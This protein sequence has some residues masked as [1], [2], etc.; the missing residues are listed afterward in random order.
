[1]SI[2]KIKNYNQKM[3]AVL[4]TLGIVLLF[5]C[6]I[7]IITDMW[8]RGYHEEVPQGLIADDKTAE[9]N[10]ENLRKQIISY[11][12]PW[13]IDTL[14]STYI[15]P[16]SIRTLKKP[17]EVVALDNG[18]LGLMDTYPGSMRFN[19]GGYY[20]SKRF[21][22]KYANLIVY[23]AVKEKAESLFSERI[24]I[25]NTQAYYF[26][27]DILLIFYLASSDTDK[28]GIIDLNDLRSLY[29]YSLN[30]GVM[31]KVS[32]GD[33]QVTDYMFEERSKN[34]LIEFQLGQYKE[35]QFE[36]DQSPKKIMKYNFENQKLINI[37]P[38]EIQQEMQKLVEGK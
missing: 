34:L 12:S 20:S 3:L 8:P 14:K 37:I 25:G 28:N 11:E 16:V 38:D 35:S 23:D 21:E 4:C 36:R 17:E 18:L 15:V 32:D 2:E 33:N 19:K 27:D 9:L 24:I 5:V 7:F 1:M 10:Q 29:I 30:S 22:G 31:R 6:I 13:L 26:Q